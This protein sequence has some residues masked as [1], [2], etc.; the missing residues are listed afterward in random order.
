MPLI[1]RVEV[2]EAHP[3]PEKPSESSNPSNR[4]PPSGESL[5]PH[6]HWVFRKP[7]R[8][9]LLG[10]FDSRSAGRFDHHDSCVEK[11]VHE[12]AMSEVDVPVLPPDKPPVRHPSKNKEACPC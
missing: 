11:A 6:R 2:H 4:S 10:H 1:P 3:C 12:R 7:Y 8:E 9:C 5:V